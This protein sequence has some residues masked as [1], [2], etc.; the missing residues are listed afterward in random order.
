MLPSNNGYILPSGEGESFWFLGVLAM[1]K[2][3]SEQTHNAFAL[4]EQIIPPG[5]EPASHVHYQQDKAFYVLEGAITIHCGDQIW[6]A[7]AGSFAFMPRG[8]YHS[9]KVES[10]TPVKM[11]VITSPGGPAGFEHF[12]E[13]MG[14]PA[15]E[16]VPPPL[17]PPDRAKL[18][19]LATEYQLEFV[20]PSQK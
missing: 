16:L 12:V 11:L 18:Q 4:Q 19:A 3:S 10:A 14:E 9:F 5:H 20:R 1:I 8:I 17:K 2:A 15:R 7:P 13:A 6:S